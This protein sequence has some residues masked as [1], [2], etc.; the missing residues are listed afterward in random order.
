MAS[1]IAKI[2]DKDLRKQKVRVK[3]YWNNCKVAN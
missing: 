3:C 2:S 1:V